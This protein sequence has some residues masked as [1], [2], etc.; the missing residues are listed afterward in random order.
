MWGHIVDSDKSKKLIFESYKNKDSLLIPI[1]VKDLVLIK[2]NEFP[3]T[4]II[5]QKSA[6]I[7]KI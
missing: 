1:K 3:D 5:L 6:I 2:L 7:G 4:T